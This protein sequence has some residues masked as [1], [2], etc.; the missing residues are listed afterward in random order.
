MTG[1]AGAATQ[2]PIGPNTPPAAAPGAP[3]TAAQPAAPVSP[4]APTAPGTAPA[5]RAISLEEAIQIA[6][7]NQGAVAVAE[8]TVE[9]ARQRVRQARV[10]T[11]PQVTAGVGYRLSGTSTLG[12]LFGSGPR[13]AGVG[14]TTTLGD[15]I[16]SNPGLQ[17]TVG[18]TYTPFD[19]GLTRTQ[20]RQARAT[21]E[22]NQAGL[23]STRN[24]LSLTVATNY[25]VQLRSQQL[26]GLR[27]VQ[28]QLALEQLRSVDARIAAGSAA[29]ADRALILSQ[30]R[31]TQVDRIQ[32]ENDLRVSAVQLRNSMGLPV[33]APLELVERAQNEQ[34]VPS[35]ELL[36]EEARRRRPEVIQDEALVRVAE[37][38]QAIARIGRKPRLDTTI[39]FNVNPNNPTTRSDYA[40]G[41]NVS[42]PLF[43]A[44]LTQ[45]RELEARSQVQAAEARLEQTKKDVA[46]DVEQ[47]YLTLVNARERLQAARLAVDASRVNLEAATARYRLGAAGTT[48]VDLIQ[49]QVQFA[50]ASNSAITALYDV[51]LAQA[52]LDRAIGR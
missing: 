12:G 29:V 18:L 26:L 8:E 44:G 14:G 20:V 2:A 30:Y 23:I 11:L 24:N 16:Q 3:S 19:S 37:A 1:I 4:V 36:R 31:N 27:R 41:A 22:S 49:A 50:T 45:A 42:L 10:G 6:Y 15:T 21:V 9:Q 33:G 32:A 34:S 39:Q 46:S 51:Q 40:I 47:A 52:Q 28:E 35:V 43:D 17:P 25:L 5:G 38:G 7:Q 48:V 13:V